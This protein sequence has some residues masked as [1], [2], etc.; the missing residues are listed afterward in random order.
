MLD[1][2]KI[3][4][5][6]A[7]HLLF[8]TAESLGND[9]NK[10]IINRSSIRRSRLRLRKQR[11][12]KIRRDYNLTKDEVVV[13]HWDGKLLP[14]LTGKTKVDRL[15]V[16]ASFNGREQ[17][18]GVPTLSTS[19]GDHQ[20]KA[21]YQTLEDWCITE[22]VQACCC[23][24]TAS[25]TGSLKG[26]CVLL[27]RLLERDILYLPC[28]HHIYELILRCV[29]DEKFGTSGPD[30]QIFKRFQTAWTNIISN[31]FEPGIKNK[32]VMESL[33][34]VQNDI[35]LFSHNRL[36][37]NHSREDY[38]ELLE[39]TVIFLGGVPSRGISF[40]LPG[41]IHHA[42]WMTKAI[43][44][45]KIYLFRNQFHL[46]QHEEIAIKS[47]C[48]FI[49]R[50]YIQ[51][52]F[53]APL[54]YKAP[55]Q[56][57]NFL[58]NLLK[59]NSI[60]KKI[61]QIAV[62]KM[63]NHLWYLSPEASA[64]SFFDKNI[65]VETKREMVKALKNED[66]SFENTKRYIQLPKYANEILNKGIKDF[67]CESS[68]KLFK[69]FS[70]NTDF[71]NIDPSNWECNEHFIKA[72][73]LIQNIPV[74]NDVAERGVKLMEDYNEKITKDEHQKQYLLQVVY[75]YRKQFPDHKKETL[76]Q[77]MS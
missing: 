52:W 77:N 6:D 40:R 7:V 38:R 63:C 16:V 10:L 66:I 49:V 29:F 15:P 28:R 33:K 50:L 13:I 65:S 62:K 20:A 48:I 11:A 27:E 9:T 55:F 37:E 19:T 25:N 5:R 53:D 45:L 24:T 51:V 41:A 4:D 54:S 72:L 3:S 21:V 44:S 57:L 30:V 8:A 67:I 12:E 39:L 60:D 32:Y 76:K 69:R 17:L 73:A 56:D 35:L 59:Y 42:R 47:I 36:K 22:Q 18:L 2:C 75:D 64:L 23:D 31:H 68:N 14:A 58:K 61:S 1:K 74:T 71:L 46:T 26:A 43:Y 34:D 70:I